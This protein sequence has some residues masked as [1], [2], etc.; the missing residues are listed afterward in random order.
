MNLM[1]LNNKGW[2]T[3]V[4]RDPGP[5]TTTL[6]S[7][8]DSGYCLPLSVSDLIALCLCIATPTGIEREAYLPDEGIEV[9]VK[10]IVGKGAIEI[11]WGKK[12]VC[13]LNTMDFLTQAA[14]QFLDQY[15]NPTTW[16]R[17]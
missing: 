17:R 2:A 13:T 9:K 6:T 4:H 8:Q 5:T 15:L 7:E 14:P 3:I 1:S 12:K 11:D 16:N 10:I